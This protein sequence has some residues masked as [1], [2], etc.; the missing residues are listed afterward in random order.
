MKWKLTRSSSKLTKDPQYPSKFPSVHPEVYQDPAFSTSP[1]AEH[2]LS[3][4]F[5]ASRHAPVAIHDRPGLSFDVDDL[6]PRRSLDSQLAEP[7]LRKQA[8]RVQSPRDPT[9][10]QVYG[11]PPQQPQ[12]S[13]RPSGNRKALDSIDELDESNPFGASLHHGG[14]YEAL[15]RG[16]QPPPQLDRVSCDITSI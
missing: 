16:R 1:P 13:S 11:S 4:P 15:Q 7:S 8:H 9:P 5:P 6:P 12:D 3:P 14:P 10:T 2:P